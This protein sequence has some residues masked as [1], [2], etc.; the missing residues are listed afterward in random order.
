M[1]VLQN[2][3]K[4]T[5]DNNESK[6]FFRYPLP[7]PFQDIVYA[8]HSLMQGYPL[9][10]L[11]AKFFNSGPFS[12]L[13]AVKNCFGQNSKSWPNFGCQSIQASGNPALVIQGSSSC[14]R[15]RSDFCVI[16]AV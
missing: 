6:Y 7:S 16:F 4:N 12:K 11:A 1:Y 15:K 9:A 14:I 8:I 2:F 5:D 3:K 13:L 10:V